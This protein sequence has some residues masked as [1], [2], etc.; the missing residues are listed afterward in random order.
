MQNLLN[1]Q[2]Q[3]DVNTSLQWVN[4]L[5]TDAAKMRGYTTI[6]QQTARTNPA[7]AETILAGA[8]ANLTDAQRTQLTQVIQRTQA[9]NA[10]N[11]DNINYGYGPGNPPPGFHYE[12]T[13][14]G[15]QRLVRD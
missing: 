12:Y 9:S 14:D 10:G 15:Q 3:Y 5:S 1:I 8:S 7:E 6:L 2:G 4:T 13:N 11:T